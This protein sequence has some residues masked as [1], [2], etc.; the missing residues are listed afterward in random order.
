[1]SDIYWSSVHRHYCHH[2]VLTHSG[3]HSEN[4][5][6]CLDDWLVRLCVSLSFSLTVEEHVWFYGRLKGLSEEEVKAELDTLLDDV[7]LLQKRHEQTKNLSGELARLSTGLCRHSSP[8]KP[9]RPFF[10]AG[11]MQRKL[12]VVIAFVGGSK[13]VVL[14][15][16]TAGVDPYSRR[17]IWDL[18]L[19]YRKG[20]L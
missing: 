7:G 12:S 4:G 9:N 20:V 6:R 1:M 16:P 8:S 11:G 10:L 2:C 14:D 19:K 5:D 15:E 17:G 18:L 13:V 3:S